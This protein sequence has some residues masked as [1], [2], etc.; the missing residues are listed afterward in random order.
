MT[1]ADLLLAS[2]SAP[3]A[4]AGDEVTVHR[5]VADSR[6][7][8]PGDLFVAMPSDRTDTRR[9]LAPAK[10]AGGA[11]VL[12]ATA[13]AWAE[14]KALGLAGAWL[15]S[16]GSAYCTALGSIA[17][18]LAGNPL[19]DRAVVAVTGTNGKT[20]TAWIIAHAR[21]AMG[22]PTA[23]LGTLGFQVAEELTELPNTTPFPVELWSLL[24][25]AAE[26]GATGIALEASSH[27]L[28][29]RRLAGVA[30]DVGVFMNLTQD[31][32]DYH[33]TMAQYA[34]AKRLLFTEMALTGGKRF[35]AVLNVDDAVGRA[36]S[37]NL[38]TAVLTFGQSADA[39]IRVETVTV[40]VDR[41]ALV[42]R[43]AGVLVELELRLGGQFNVENSLAAFAALRAL[44]HSGAQIADA[45]SEVPPVPG[46]FEPVPNDLG[47]GVLVDYAHTPDALTKL[48]RSAR[49]VTAGRVLA[50]FGCGGDRDRSKR[51]LMAAAVS[52]DADVTVL[53][54]DNPRTESPSE[55]LRDAATGLIAGKTSHVEPDRPLAVDWAIQ[56][57][58][59]GDTVVLAGKGHETTQIIGHTK[60]PMD[61]RE[62]A[63]TALARRGGN[64]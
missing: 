8:R 29:E 17:R 12:V 5:L 64:R 62:L 45:L 54:S 27:A 58:R 42:V 56:Q 24:A 39:N 20:T 47:I 31:H 43:E 63:R 32:L 26:E 28:E 44:G 37:T 1:L 53:T 3:I 60:Y 55:I 9:F 51:P 61:D 25:Q 14:A 34:A 21:R 11:G 52:A 41:I 6:S 48:L 49:A 40:G 50:V 30:C 18:S 15:P 19:A 4:V 13:E 46:R 10:E 16:T 23:Y 7:V 57:A 2:P 35:T 59:P 33:G 36:W 22:Q 38:P